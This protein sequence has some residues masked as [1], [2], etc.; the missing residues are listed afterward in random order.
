MVSRPQPGFTLIELM[1]VLAIV[2]ILASIAVPS[3]TQ[4]IAKQRLSSVKAEL[5]SSLVRTRSEAI[6]LNQD[7]TLQPATGGWINGWTVVN[8]K[9][10][11]V[12]FETHDALKGVTVT[13]SATSVVFKSNGRVNA[14]AAP[15]F[16]LSATGTASVMCVSLD[17][18]GR[19]KQKKAAC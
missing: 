18:S 10:G 4:L 3:F 19:P 6:K 16:Q 7:V 5:F 11:G 14:T 13:T 8:P 12:A 9:T 17:V 15:S 2:V 1:V